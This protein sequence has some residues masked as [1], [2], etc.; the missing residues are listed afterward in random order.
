MLPSE[1]KAP[2]CSAIFFSGRSIPSNILD[3]IPG[4]KLA[5]I[6]A[7]VG[8]T[9]S[10]GQSPVVDSYTCMVVILSFTLITSPIRRL[11]PTYTISSME[12]SL[13]SLT[14]TTGP[15]IE[16]ITLFNSITFLSSG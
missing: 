2:D 3:N 4:P 12:K 13:L 6:G 8:S 16:N 14:V 9:G 10:P 1:I 15:L 7:P 5:D 11:F